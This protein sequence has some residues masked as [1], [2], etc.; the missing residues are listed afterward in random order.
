MKII[1]MNTI[2]TSK[3][4]RLDHLIG[5]A[6]QISI[7][8][9]TR[10]DGDAVGSC[11]ALMHYLSE[12]RN[13]NVG[14]T[15][16]DPVP[17]SISF[18]IPEPDRNR[19]FIQSKDATSTTEWIKK[20]DLVFCLDC[21]SFSRTDK[22]QDV[23]TE[24]KAEKVLIDHHL[25]P[26]SAEFDLVFSEIKISS[27]AELLF[28]ILLEMPEISHDA[29]KL[30]IVTSNSLMAG[31][32]TDTNNFANSTFPSTLNMASQLLSVGVNRD[33]ILS[34]LYNCFRENRV[35]IMGH[36]F[37]DMMVITNNGVAYMILDKEAI[38]KYDVHEGETEG[39]V[40]IPLSIKK[41][42][43]SILL[44]QDDGYFR[45]SIRS[46]RGTSANKCALEYFNGGG[47]E[48]AAGG[49]LYF[50]KDI[51]NSSMAAEYIERVTDIF[52][53]K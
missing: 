49:R 44:K 43:M 25:S 36:I 21:N 5:N 24:S 1:G 38:D 52:L 12:C 29:S 28:Y 30:P 46:K 47:H 23:Y 16:S 6:V 35:R 14:I 26:D 13:C 17:D 45:V 32:T 20:S 3:V 8:S 18:L 40:N 53:N 33:K 19:I 22:L 9:H 37:K 50:P 39:F 15:F 31:M 51:A 4:T 27:T 2:E 34:N 10:E 7:V 48:L 11:I 41:V 42:K